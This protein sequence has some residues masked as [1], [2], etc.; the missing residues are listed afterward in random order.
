MLIVRL[1]IGRSRSSK[2]IEAMADR[3]FLKWPFFDEPH[4][5][6][7]ADLEGWAF[8][9]V[10]DT[11]EAEH[12]ADAVDAACRRLVRLLGDA[13]WLKYCVPAS[14]GGMPEALDMRSLCLMRET[15]ARYS[16]LADFAFAMQGLGSGPLTLYG[17]ADQRARYLPGVHR[18]EQIMAFALSEP[19][20]GSDVAAIQTSA[21]RDGDSHVL[22]GVKTWISNGGIADVYVVF[23]R[24]GEPGSGSRGLSAFIVQA[25]TPGFNVSERIR[26]IAPHPLATL[27]FDGCRVPTA[28]RIGEEGDGFKIAMGTLDVFRATVGAA[29]LGFA[30]RALDEAVARVQ[31]RHAFGQTLSEFQLVKEKLADMA[32]AVDA[33]AL[34]VYR[35]AWAKDKSTE[36]VSR[37]SAMA[38][39]HATE[40]AQQ[41]VDTAVQLFGGLGLVSGQPVERLYREV[42]ALRIYEGTTDIQKLVVAGQI[43]REHA[44]ASDLFS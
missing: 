10:L 44:V 2:V 20:A 36:R 27:T 33:S 12:D 5:R 28:N 21:R 30:R 29:A 4:R 39:W 13:G 43:L 3:G 31:L 41:V 6:L 15:L 11:G 22:D 37:E 23:A 16:G 7:A 14:A 1:R 25:G 35:A 26:V 19:D 18:G 38:K 9:Q 34:L 24:S 42:R 8:G 32:L 17:S 40:A